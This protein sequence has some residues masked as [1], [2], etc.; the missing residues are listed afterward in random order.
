MSSVA[1]CPAA[2]SVKIGGL[3]PEATTDVDGATLNVADD[4]GAI[5]AR[6]SDAVAETLTE[7]GGLEGVIFAAWVAGL[8]PTTTTATATT[9]PT[10]LTARTTGP[11]RRQ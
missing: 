2:T 7:V 4:K 5:D 10:N 11:R 1:S 6:G 3:P 9:I 8:H